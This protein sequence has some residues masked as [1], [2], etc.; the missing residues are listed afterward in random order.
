MTDF[1]S[2]RRAWRIEAPD[3][4]TAPAEAVE[5]VRDRALALSRTMRRRDRLETVVALLL[6]PFF[7]WIAVA[8]PS[9]IST[10]GAVVVAAWC[11]LMPLRLRHARGRA[12]D[13]GQPVR[14][15]LQAE[16]EHTRS[17]RRLLGSVAWWYVAPVTVGVILIV[18]GGDASPAFKMGYSGLVLL[19]GLV[20]LILNR[21]A[22]QH[23]LQ[24]MIDNLERWLA[25]LDPREAADPKP[26]G[27]LN[28]E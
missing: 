23:T 10:A 1:E 8:E 16:L 11:I 7:S 14:D 5:R 13:P 27:D 19:L 25:E 22:A 21:R 28:D 4:S 6:F 26:E 17:Q 12:S 24:P 18:A 3:A 20:V 2:L 9:P 15:F